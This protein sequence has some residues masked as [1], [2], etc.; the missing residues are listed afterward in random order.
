MATVTFFHAHPDDEAIA[1]GGT[2]ASLAAEGHRVVLVT[3]TRGELGEVPDGFLAADETLGARR[4]I[5]LARAAD[6]LGVARH[7]FLGYHDSG[8][9]G[10]E[11]NARPDCFATADRVEAAGR[12][13]AILAEESADVLVVYDEHG[14][15]GH[16]DHV[17]VHDVGVMAADLAA[18]PVL[19]LST[20]DRDFML[21]L[22]RRAAESEFGPDD[23]E[24]EGADTMGEPGA[25]ITTEVDVT[26]W[27]EAKR[28]A[29]RAHASQ[30]A[31]D[32][33]FLAM[34]DDLFADVWG[35]EWFIRVR[36]DPVGLGDGNREDGLVVDPDGILAGGATRAGVP[37]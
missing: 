28:S 19:Y 35:Q 10:E 16:P 9:E 37:G 15:Y 2:M 5:E 1:T 7:E 34:P 4:E 24:L 6:V 22:R 11:S 21:E 36:P 8:M 33:F 12:L 26:P 20:M 29:M 14:G 27:V 31:E 32:S 23:D 18:T 25:R 17:Q 3:A 13:A 30:I